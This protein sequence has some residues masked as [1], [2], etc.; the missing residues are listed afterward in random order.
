MTVPF[1]ISCLLPYHLVGDGAYVDSASMVTPFE[2][3]HQGMVHLSETL[4]SS[5]A[6]SKV[7][8]IIQACWK[9]HDFC[10]KDWCLYSW[11]GFNGR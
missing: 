11:N 2:R 3:I 5:L 9:L 4:G 7:V 6:P 1:M 8:N 10:Q